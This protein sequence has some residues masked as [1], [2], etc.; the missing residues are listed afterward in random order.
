MALGIEVTE[1]AL[2]ELEA[3]LLNKSGQVPLHDRFRAL[4]TLKAVGGQAAVNIIGKGE[5]GSLQTNCHSS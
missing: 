1:S 2:D 5:Q 4:F 3:R